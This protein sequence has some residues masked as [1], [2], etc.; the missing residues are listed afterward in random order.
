MTTA[1]VIVPARNAADMIGE[2]IKSLRAQTVPVEIIIVDDGSD[3]GTAA[4]AKKLGAKVL[5]QQKKGPASARNLGAGAAKGEVLLFTDADCVPESGWVEMMLVPFSDR[6]IAGAQGA[7]KTR[8]KSWV[9]RFAQLEIEDRYDRLSK[10]EYIDFI[11]TY[12]AAYRKTV[13]MKAG[14]FDEN[15]TAASG[16]DPELSFRVAGAGGKMVFTPRAIVYHRHPDS[17]AKYA[18]QKF[19][20]ALWRVPLYKKHMKKAAG[21]SYTP[22]SLKVETG[23]FLMFAI[24]LAAWPIWAGRA[25]PGF[26]PEIFLG[27][28]VLLSLPFAAKNFRKDKPAG[29]VTPFMV[30]VRSAVFSAGLL[31]G[32]LKRQ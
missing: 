28:I 7:Y 32:M 14:G 2:C 12:S 5:R 6:S 19:G 4:L 20:R 16:E 9:A 26:S 1:T 31:W 30:V 25:P 11:G 18:K 27:A 3:D 24:S 29:L 8:Q 21:E 23:L 22:Q 13:F 17:L 15:F 10:R